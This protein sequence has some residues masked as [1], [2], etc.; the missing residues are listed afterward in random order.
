MTEALIVVDVQNDF[1]PGGALAVNDG[2]LIIPLVNTMISDA[3]LVIF[4]QDWHPLDHS[5]F[6]A[7]HI[8]KNAFEQ[9]DMHYGPQTLWP[10]HCVQGS[11][12]A[13]FH[14]DIN[15]NAADVIIRKG[16]NKDIDSY[17]AFYENDQTTPTGLTGLLKEKNVSSVKFVGLALDFCVAFSALDAVKHDFDVSVVMDACKAI[18]NQGSLD[19][20]ITRMRNAGV[21]LI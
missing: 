20:A 2:H 10:T 3:D 15:L 8:G 7:N 9:I 12:G 14:A 21:Q 16:M 11:R 18:D 6:S 19:S 17:S 4:S 5:S 13:E 1:C